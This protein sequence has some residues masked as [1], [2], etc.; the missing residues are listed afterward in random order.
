MFDIGTGRGYLGCHLALMH[1]LRVIGVDSSSSNT[2]SAVTRTRHL[3]KQWRGLVRVGFISVPL[4][5]IY[6]ASIDC[7]FNY[8][9]INIKL[10][11]INDV[12]SL[13][14]TGVLMCS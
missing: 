1:G 12:Y 6:F 3:Q 13:K 8:L 4:A 5:Q 11:P 14:W 2:G 7:I 10:R 9:L